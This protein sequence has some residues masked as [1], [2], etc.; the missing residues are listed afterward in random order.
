MKFND[1]PVAMTS[2]APYCPC[3]EL[4]AWPDGV[5]IGRKD[6][7]V[8]LT[9]PRC[10]SVV[11]AQYF[12]PMPVPRLPAPDSGDCHR[13]D[14]GVHLSHDYNSHT[15]SCARCGQRWNPSNPAICEPCRGCST[16]LQDLTQS[17]QIP[18][19]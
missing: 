19:R 13:A 10:Q 5:M 9:C 4:L 1:V 14:A 18:V 7:P 15:D 6:R 12:V 16:S 17:R 11:R 3:G 8:L 2:Q